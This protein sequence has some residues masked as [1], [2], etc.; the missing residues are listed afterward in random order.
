MEIEQREYF[1]KKEILERIK[2]LT[3][4]IFCLNVIITIGLIELFV[5]YNGFLL[6]GIVLGIIIGFIGMRIY[7]KYKRDKAAH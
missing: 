1:T 7:R 5:Y 4:V 2:W 3:L 6:L